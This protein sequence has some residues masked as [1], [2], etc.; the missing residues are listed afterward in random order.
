MSRQ[1]RHVIKL[2]RELVESENQD[3]RRFGRS[4]K[5]L[6]SRLYYVTN[7]NLRNMRKTKLSSVTQLNTQFS[8]F[9]DYELSEYE[10]GFKH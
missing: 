2:G 10:L 9:E 1:T 8:Q 7:P 6:N 3:A 4:L 5:G